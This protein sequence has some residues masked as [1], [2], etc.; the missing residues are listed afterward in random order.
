MS[1]SPVS[2]RERSIDVAK[3]VA[4]AM[5]VLGHVAR[6][7]Q[8][9]D[10]V[11]STGPWLA[12]DRGLYLC[13]LT[14]FAF[15]SGLFVRRGVE[16]AGAPTYWWRRALLLTWL[17]LLWSLIQG[18]VKVAVGG[19]AN[20]PQSPLGVLEVWRPEGQLWFFPW[21]VVAIALAVVVQP[22]HAPRGLIGIGV[23]AVAGV[24]AWGYD[25]TWIF[26]RGTALYAPFLLG[27]AVGSAR[28]VGWASSRG[29]R[30]TALTAVAVVGWVA[31]AVLTT[32]TPPTTG[33]ADRT[34]TSVALG[35]AG[36]ALGTV[37]VLLMA[38]RL[39]GAGVLGR[40]VAVV[41]RGSTEILLAHIVVASGTRIALT[42][43]GVTD[44][45]VHLVAG[46]SLGVGA[47]LLLRAWARR[48]RWDWVFGL[49]IRLRG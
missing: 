30:M 16:R 28:Y 34:W 24:L 26:G 14:V 38:K 48:L 7:L 36:W 32:A 33:G 35:L 47:P 19:L 15:L 20:Q 11:A 9:S 39:A 8:S 44:P 49:P 40:G 3:G 31:V 21:L 46:T 25:P 29:A 42:Q 6:G 10:L 43:A 2:V 1:G 27:C 4:M 13:H 5:V 41:G 45:W 18:G 17:F 12:L 37:A 22:W 23:A